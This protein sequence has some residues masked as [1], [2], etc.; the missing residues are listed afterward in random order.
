MEDFTNLEKLDMD[1]MSDEAIKS[2]GER[3]MAEASRVLS[4]GLI[5]A[6]DKE[7]INL[8]LAISIGLY[9]KGLTENKFNDEVKIH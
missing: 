7:M 2:F 5:V 8:A 9:M 4:T 3:Y 1:S 6:S